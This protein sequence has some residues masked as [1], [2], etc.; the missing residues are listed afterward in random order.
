MKKYIIWI[1]CFMPLLSFA[2]VAGDVKALK[3][4]LQSINQERKLARDKANRI[5]AEYEKGEV[6]EDEID[7]EYQAIESQIT[8]LNG[9]KQDI[10]NRIRNLEVTEAQKPLTHP[11]PKPKEVTKESTPPPSGGLASYGGNFVADGLLLVGRIVIFTIAFVV[12][13][14]CI[15]LA[16]EIRDKNKVSSIEKI[17]LSGKHSGRVP[18]HLL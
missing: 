17:E 12:I 1:L 15:G 14:F 18:D 10:E 5:F 16:I 3:L 11:V 13:L 2:E 7:H 4:Q 6:D 9:Q 8:A